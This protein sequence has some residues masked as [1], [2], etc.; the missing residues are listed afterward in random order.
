MRLTPIGPQVI[1]QKMTPQIYLR[2][3]NGHG[4]KRIVSEMSLVKKVPTVGEIVHCHNSLPNRLV[5]CVHRAFHMCS[6]REGSSQLG[7]LRVVVLVWRGVY[8][9]TGFAPRGGRSDRSVRR[10]TCISLFHTFMF[11]TVGTQEESYYGFAHSDTHLRYRP[12]HR[13]SGDGWMV[14]V[15]RL[16]RLSFVAYLICIS[17]IVL[18]AVR[19]L[20]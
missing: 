15:S 12:T 11:Y 20:S 8:T 6:A 13:M 18:D 19:Y 14:S 10:R 16:N 5:W 17:A 1:T 9:R 7:R 4:A 2:G 3:R